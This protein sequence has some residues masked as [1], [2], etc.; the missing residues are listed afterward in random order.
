MRSKLTTVMAVGLWLAAGASA[1]PTEQHTGSNPRPPV[2]SEDF[3]AEGGALQRALSGDPRLSIVPGEGVGGSRALRASYVGGPM[4]SER[5]VRSIPLGQPGLEYTLSY[6]VK[7]DRDFQFV[8]GGKLHGLGPERPVAGGNPI[9]P[10]GWSA[11]VMWRARGRPELYTYHQDQRG[12][13]GDHGAVLRS[14]TFAPGRYHSV[15][16]HVRLNDPVEAANGAVHLYVDGKRVEAQERVRL[17]GADGPDTL[18][19]R[20]LFSTFHGGNDPSWA[21]RAPDGSFTKVH[22]HFDNFEVRPGEHPRRGPGM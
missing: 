11:R 15:S 5:L 19:G 21:P 20:L 22:A 4:G 9:R 6:D 14:V 16:L 3:E 8:L 1:A 2:L 18:I 7:F 13:Y 12:R 17:R 10:D